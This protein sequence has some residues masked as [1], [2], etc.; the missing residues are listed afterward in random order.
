MNI[1]NKNFKIGSC[2]FT[3]SYSG[4]FLNHFLGFCFFFYGGRVAIILDVGVST[5]QQTKS[6][7]NHKLKTLFLI[8]GIK[9]DK[10]RNNVNKLMVE[11]S[12][13]KHGILNF[14]ES[15]MKRICFL[16]NELFTG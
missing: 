8:L 1:T 14:Q 7:G 5:D 12:Y 11:E 3:S 13:N 6:R 4:S 15:D 2:D 10:H 9:K 16:H